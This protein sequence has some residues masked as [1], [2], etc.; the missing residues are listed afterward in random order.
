MFEVLQHPEFVE[1]LHRLRDIQAKAR[2]LRR[3]NRLERGLVGDAKFIEAGV[4]EL[5]ID[6]GPGY[7]LYFIQRGGQLI[8][9]LC[10]GDKASQRADIA[11]ALRIAREVEHG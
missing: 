8:V 6:Y 1:W 9:M 5:R 7:R 10:G 2:I 3:L 11:Q 4:R